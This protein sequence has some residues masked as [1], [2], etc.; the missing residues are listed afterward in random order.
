MKIPLLTSV[1]FYV[2]QVTCSMM[3]RTSREFEN[4]HALR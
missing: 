3:K 2:E 1:F 4:V